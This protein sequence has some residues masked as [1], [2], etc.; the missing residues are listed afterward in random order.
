MA[1]FHFTRLDEDKSAEPLIKS[2][3]IDANALIT[4]SEA[5]RVA[6]GESAVVNRGTTDS[7]PS[8]SPFENLRLISAA[9]E[10]YS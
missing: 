6:R 10:G 3:R 8:G 4:I 5:F 7:H 2:G 1:S 9:S